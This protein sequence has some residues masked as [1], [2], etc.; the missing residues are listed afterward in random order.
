M[1]V[2]GHRAANEATYEVIVGIDPVA[3][4]AIGRGPTDLTLP[5]DRSIGFI[6]GVIANTG[7]TDAVVSQAHSSGNGE[8]RTSGTVVVLGE[9]HRTVALP[10]S[11]QS[12]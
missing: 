2:N 12:L 9:G 3:T 4:I 7:T 5:I 8:G 6:R 10:D 1:K 11:R